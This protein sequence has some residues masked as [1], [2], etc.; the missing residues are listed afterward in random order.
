MASQLSPRQREILD[1]VAEGRTSK[2]IAVTLGIS[3]STVNWHL[4]NAFE[5]LGASSRAEAVARAI[6]SNGAD[7][8][9]SPAR[10]P[11]APAPARVAWPRLVAVAIA[12]AIAGAL[13]GGA[14]VATLRLGPVPVPTASPATGPVAPPSSPAS[15]SGQNVV[16]G[17]IA[18]ES[19]TP[20]P[21]PSL[22]LRTPRLSLP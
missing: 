18:A 22:P 13:L 15:G 10:I 19:P 9:Q 3:E 8:P 21:L 12:I 5:R 17:E 20:P 11:S 4:A 7:R 6:R 14:T 2:E 16:R 1:L